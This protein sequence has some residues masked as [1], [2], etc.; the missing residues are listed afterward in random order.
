MLHLFSG[1]I[2]PALRLGE[3]L[4]NWPRIAQA[5]AE[6]PRRRQKQMQHLCTLISL[7]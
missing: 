2:N 4:R 5:L 1:A 6:R 3:A 7:S